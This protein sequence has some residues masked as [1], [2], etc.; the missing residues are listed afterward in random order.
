[1]E[2]PWTITHPKWDDAYRLNLVIV[3]CQ[4]RILTC[5]CDVQTLLKQEKSLKHTEKERGRE[6]RRTRSTDEMRGEENIQLISSY[7]SSRS[8]SM[9][10]FITTLNKVLRTSG[11]Y[12]KLCHRAN[13]VIMGAP[14]SN[15]SSSSPSLPP[16]LS[17]FWMS[18]PRFFQLQLLQES[19]LSHTLR[20]IHI[21]APSPSHSILLTPSTLQ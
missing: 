11:L 10:I 14:F 7:P 12:L 19:A 18:P 1:M 5:L 4:K 2:L 21:R 6:E 3:W 16:S 13:S 15:S 20:V 9:M 8:N 17:L